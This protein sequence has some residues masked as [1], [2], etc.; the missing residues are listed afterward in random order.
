MGST[1]FLSRKI[2][3][4][5]G[6]T[7]TSTSC[8]NGCRVSFV[9]RVQSTGHSRSSRILRF[10]A[11]TSRRRPTRRKRLSSRLRL[12]ERG[13]LPGGRNHRALCGHRERAPL[14]PWPPTVCLAAA[15]PLLVAHTDEAGDRP[16]RPAL[17]SVEGGRRRRTSRLHERRIEGSG[18]DP[19]GGSSC[20]SRN[21]IAGKSRVP[22]I[23]ILFDG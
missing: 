5:L 1:S 4:H 21:E 8:R 9:S 22:I 16:L 23:C 18:S 6:Q 3:W 7:S 17:G 2:P 20:S 12:P 10:L 15:N 19:A 11:N 14:S 13:V